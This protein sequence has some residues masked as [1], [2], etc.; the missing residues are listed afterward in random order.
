MSKFLRTII[1]V[2][3]VFS[4]LSCFHDGSTRSHVK[5]FKYDGSIQCENTGLNLE[6]MALE[7]INAGIDVVCSQKGHDGLIRPAVCGG[8]T[9]IINIYKIHNANLP[10]AENIGFDSVSILSE[11][12]DEICE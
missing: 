11:Y 10:D 12:S 9:G 2:I 7:L 4:M 6:V 3:S 8:D 1:I 5:V